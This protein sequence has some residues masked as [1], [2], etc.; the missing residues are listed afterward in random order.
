MKVVDMF[1]AK[2]PCLAQR[3]L[4]I[5]ELVQEDINGKIFGSSDELVEEFMKVLTN[6]HHEN[7]TRDLVKYR[8]NLEEFVRED[9]DT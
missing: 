6:F 1:S 7:L 3:Y 2:L 5:G 4:C 9:W 8:E